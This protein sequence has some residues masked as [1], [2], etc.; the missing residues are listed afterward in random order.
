MIVDKAPC[1]ICTKRHMN[2]HAT[3]DEYK[4]WRQILEEDKRHIVNARDKELEL[5]E[6]K[7]S[8]IERLKSRK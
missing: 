4:E 7:F 8:A 3:C 6:I 1:K 2:C 5:R